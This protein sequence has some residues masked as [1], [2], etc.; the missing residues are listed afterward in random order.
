[1]RLVSS[2]LL[3][4]AVALVAV[5]G[6]GFLKSLVGKNTVDLEGAEVTSMSVDL[7]RTVKTIC[8]REPVQMGVFLEVTLKGEA[9]KKP[10]ETWAGPPGTSKNDKLDFAEFA[11]HSDQGTFDDD[12]WFTPNPDLRATLGKELVLQTAYKK[13]PDKF[14][15]DL[16]FKPDYGCIA[17]AGKRGAPGAAG[18]SGERGQAGPDGQLASSTGAGGPGGEGQPGRVGQG[19]VDGGDGPRVKAFVTRVKTPFYDSLVAVRLTGD[20]DDFLLF[21]IDKPIKLEAI[22]GPGGPGGAGGEGG[23]G[24]RGGGGNPGGNGGNGGRGADGGVGGKGGKGGQIEVVVDARNA[25]LAR[26]VAADVAGGPGGEPGSGGRGGTRGSGG[27]PIGQGAQRGT[28]AAE[29]PSGAAGHG[30]PRGADGRAE[31]HPGSI[32]DAF[33]G[34]D[35]LTVLGGDTG[36]TPASPATSPAKVDPKATTKKGTRK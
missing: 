14:S 31:V 35:G 5:P 20:L 26:L 27:G 24:G 28:D 25:D 17:A 4:A 10:F 1:M 11:F 2:S 29:G 30:G 13:R 8:P 23:P 12:G 9:E 15:F 21:P 18:R 19:G 32:G 3:L 22:G 33:A 16:K 6:C 7:R 36:A 34:I